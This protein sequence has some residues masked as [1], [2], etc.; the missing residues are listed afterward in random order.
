MALL[1][2]LP[3]R[4]DTVGTLQFHAQPTLHLQ[5]RG[6]RIDSHAQARDLLRDIHTAVHLAGQLA[7]RNRNQRLH[8]PVRDDAGQPDHRVPRFAIHHLQRTAQ[9]Q[10][11]TPPEKDGHR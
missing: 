7:G 4:L 6:E 9:H 11:L 2:E 8:R 5:I 3:H 1:A 10:S